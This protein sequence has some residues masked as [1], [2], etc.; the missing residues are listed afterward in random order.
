MNTYDDY[1]EDE[2]N[3]YNIQLSIQNSCREAFL[4]SSASLAA[5]TDENLRVLAAIE[6]GEVC[7]LEELLRHPFAFRELDC[8]GW[9]PLHRAAAQPLVEV[10]ETVLTLAAKG[11]SLEERTAVGG[12]TPL[13]LAVKAGWVKNVRSLI[14]HGA[15]PHNTNSKS[16]TPLLLAVRSGSYEMTHLLVTQ[17]AW[18]EQICR[19]RWTAIHEAAK[20]GNS[21]ILMLLLRNGGRVNQKDITGATPLAVAAEHGHF[22]IIEILVNCGSK[23]NSQACNGESVLL[24][25]A[26]SGNVACIKFLLDNG[27]NPNLHS[28]TGHLPIHKAAYA[29]HYDALKLLI[30]LTHKKAIKEAGQSPVHS[31]AEGGHSRCLKLLLAS[32]FDVNYRMNTRNSENYRDM[33]RSALYFAVSNGDVECAR[34]LLAAGAKTDLDPLCSLLVAVRSGRYEIVK[35]LL[36]AKADVN[37]YFNVVSDTVFPT[38]LQ[39]CLKDEMMMRLLLNN[40]YKV[41]TCFQCHHDSQPSV[42]YEREEK[43]PFCEFMSLC[44]IAHLSGSVVLTLLDYVKHVHICSTLRLILEKQKEWPEIC[45][46]QRSPRSLKHLCRLEIRTRL[47]LKRLNNP[48]IMH[49]FPPRLKSYILYQELDLYSRD[50]QS[51]V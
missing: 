19:K 36:A 29:G 33:R 23:V 35:L 34:V 2:L 37:C 50:F 1:S 18:V 8:R 21:D 39:Y 5:T 31:A 48:E 20:V 42:A 45:H 44:C 27:A 6:H 10:L 41:E 11:L 30:P 7:L 51:Y 47:T 16:E 12:E 9:L 38:A 32:G 14:K 4:K 3:D 28:A 25:A 15:N 17:G 22:H 40:G 26:G 43:I 46:I 49:L 13:T 24:D